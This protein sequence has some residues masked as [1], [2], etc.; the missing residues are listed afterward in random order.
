MYTGKSL[1]QIKIDADGKD[2]IAKPRSQQEPR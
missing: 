2:W 1:T